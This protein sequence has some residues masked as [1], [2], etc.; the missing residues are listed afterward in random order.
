MRDA[1]RRI[2]SE[3][4]RS[5]RPMNETKNKQER[6]YPAPK[7]RELSESEKHYIRSRIDKDE[8]EKGEADSF[9]IST[10]INCSP[11]QVAGIMG[12]MHRP[13]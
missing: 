12:A 13:K 5:R 4:T 6:R 8:A 7:T 9:A 10:E 3:M 1:L 2:E 11:S